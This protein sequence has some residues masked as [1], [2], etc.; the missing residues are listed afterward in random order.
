MATEDHASVGSAARELATRL[1][2]LR[3]G[4]GLS[5]R[6]LARR[7]GLTA[8][9]GLVDYE[10]GKRIPPADLVTSYERA[11]GLTAGSLLAMR[12]RAFVERGR[13]RV[14]AETGSPAV[15]RE[16]TAIPV[17]PLFLVASVVLLAAVV[18]GAV[19]VRRRVIGTRNVF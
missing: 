15:P 1:R 14:E 17:W 11:F 18:L 7:L 2:Q 16:K 5:Y 4:H 12:N 9:S 19:T 13:R 10:T 6:L 3:L 8:H